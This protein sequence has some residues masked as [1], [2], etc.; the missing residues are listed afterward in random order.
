MN[1]LQKGSLID[2]GALQNELEKYNYIGIDFS[3]ILGLF[4]GIIQL[5]ILG[6]IKEC[7]YMMVWVGTIVNP[8]L[9]LEN[10]PI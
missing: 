4:T 1:G 6:G 8:V 2:Q 7:K 10:F 5:P 3:K 9:P